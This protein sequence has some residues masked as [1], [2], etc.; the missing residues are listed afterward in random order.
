MNNEDGKRRGLV[1]AGDIIG[2]AIPA[3]LSLEPL[4]TTTRHPPLKPTEFENK[5]LSLFQNMLCNTEE[6]KERFSNAI[7]LWDSI[8]RYAVSRQAMARAREKDKFLETHTAIFHYRD[9]TYAVTIS[10]ARVT[11]LDG[12]QRDYYPSTTEELVEDALRKLAI[13]QQAGF[14]DKPSYRSGVVFTIYA[15]REE[16]AKRGH[17]RSYQEIVLALN[18]LAKSNIEIKEIGKGELLAVSPYLPALVAVS[19]NRLKDDPKAK[20]AAQFHPFVTDSIDKVTYRQFNYARMM[21]HEGRLARWLHKYLA[22][23]YTFAD[24]TKPF[25]IHYTTIKRDSGLLNEYARERAAIDAVRKAFD[26][27]QEKGV[28]SRFERSDVTGLRK[29]LLDVV[30]TIWPSFDFVKEVKAANKR[31]LNA[32]AKAVGAGGGTNRPIGSSG[33]LR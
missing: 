6:E 12:K 1:R 3:S 26:D 24:Y 20:W 8:P 17:A 9:R 29:K 15:L 23:K 14:F 11:D 7:D 10:P 30:F 21:S 5:Q 27:L 2:D 32:R 33:E 13:D 28:L 25:R 16:L 4:E 18:I 22:L 31:Q 19:K